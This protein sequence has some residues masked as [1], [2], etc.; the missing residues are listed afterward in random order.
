MPAELFRSDLPST[1]APRRAS[2]LPVSLAV[3]VAVIATAVLMPVLADGDLPPV[4]QGGPIA[5]TPVAPPPPRRRHPS[6]QRGRA[7]P[8]TSPT[9]AP[10]DAPAEISPEP[11]IEPTTIGRGV[12]LGDLAGVDFGQA[13]GLALPSPAY[14]AAVAAGRAEAGTA[15]REDRTAADRPSR[16]ARLSRYRADLASAGHRRDRSADW[17]RRPRAQRRRDEG[18]G[19]AERRRAH[20]RPS[21]GLHANAAQRRARR[22]NHDGDGRLQ[23]AVDVRQ[24]QRHGEHKDTRRTDL[25]TF[26]CTPIAGAHPEAAKALLCAS[27]VPSV[28]LWLTT[29]E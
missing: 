22:G 2:L 27:S 25:A 19:R 23:P 21:V 13:G 26:G 17:H 5:Y 16:A 29:A 14:S 20:R 1:T 8:Q 12:D 28:S 18:K 11:A 6:G 9:K 7:A 3:H 4:V 10:L 24:P 15:R